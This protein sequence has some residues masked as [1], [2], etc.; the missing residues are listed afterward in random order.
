VHKRQTVQDELREG[1]QHH[2]DDD[3][4]RDRHYAERKMI[5]ALAV[6]NILTLTD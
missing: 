3:D 4:D 1:M 6:G 5:L 2:Y